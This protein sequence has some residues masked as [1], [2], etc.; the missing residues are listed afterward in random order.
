MMKK[1][2]RLGMFGMILI[3]GI[4]NFGCQNSQDSVSPIS[5]NVS[6]DEAEVHVNGVATTVTSSVE[7]ARRAYYDGKSPTLCKSDERPVFSLDVMDYKDRIVGKVHLMWSPSCHTYWSRVTS[8]DAYSRTLTAKIIRDNP[9]DRAYKTSGYGT[10][11]QTPMVYGK[12]MT[13]LACGH[14][15]GKIQPEAKECTYPIVGR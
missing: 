7:A 12:G 10:M 13:V 5:E 9:F 8:K 15:Y 11:V 4:I 3:V 14:G 2:M 1:K 6:N